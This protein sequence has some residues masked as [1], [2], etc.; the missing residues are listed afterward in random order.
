M[1]VLA[2]ETALPTA[3][4]IHVPA[5]IAQPC[6]GAI[7]IRTGDFCRT[8]RTKENVTLNVHLYVYVT[9]MTGNFRKINLFNGLNL[10]DQDRG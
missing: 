10:I 6:V 8:C 5:Q 2:L 3:L 1:A 4:P 9:S 7:A